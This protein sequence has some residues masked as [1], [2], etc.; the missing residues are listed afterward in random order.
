VSTGATSEYSRSCSYPD[1]SFTPAFVF[2]QGIPSPCAFNQNAAGLPNLVSSLTSPK[3]SVAEFQ[4]HGNIPLLQEWSLGFQHQF[5]H[6]WIGEV[7][8]IGNKGT[9]L[10]VTLA[11]NQIVPTA[12]CCYGVSNNQTLRPYPQW[13]NVNYFSY[14][15]NS[16]YNALIL[17]MQH[18]WKHGLSALFTYTWGK[19]MDDVDASARS[20]A[21]ANQNT[22]NVASQ[23]GVA[24]TD[25]PQRFTAAYVWAVPVGAGGKLAA[26]IPVVSQIIGHW[27]FSGITQFQPGY[28]YTISQTN[29]NGL[30]NGAQYTSRTGVSPYLSNPTIGEWFNPA[31]FS[32]TPAD[33]FGTTPRAALFGPGLNNFDLSVLRN[34]PIKERFTFQVR[35]DFYNAFNHLQLDNLNTTI[36]NPAFGAATGD[37]GARTIQLDARV[38]F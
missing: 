22:Y 24:M 23:Y 18:T 9:H 1:T 21:V 4:T 13:L 26:N 10:P 12:G 7:D 16:N 30:F 11:M 15:G 32:I 27:E 29:T 3:Q 19:T 38:T 17:S 35:G 31:A 2:A 34:F 33:T 5:A 6:G 8:Y 36:T 14:S 37:A 28:P 25:I 20:D